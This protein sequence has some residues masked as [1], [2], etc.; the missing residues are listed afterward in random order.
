MKKELPI[1]PF[2]GEP[3]DPAWGTRIQKGGERTAQKIVERAVKRE[4]AIRK[5]AG[6]SDDYARTG[7][8]DT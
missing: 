1:S 7:T 4:E 8:E 2:T 5:K 3:Y 6:T